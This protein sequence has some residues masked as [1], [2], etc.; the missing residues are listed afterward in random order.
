MG[1]IVHEQ[2][3]RKSN[4]VR[5]PR[6]TGIT[7]QIDAGHHVMRTGALSHSPDRRAR[8]T[9]TLVNHIFQAGCRNHFHFRRAM[10]VD[11][12][13]EN[14]LDFICLHLLPSSFAICH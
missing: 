8:K 3:G 9:G 1:R 10:D 14:E 7:I 13:S 5:L 6:Q 12:L 4:G 11:K 2:I